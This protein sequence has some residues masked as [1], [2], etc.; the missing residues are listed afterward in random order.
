[1]SRYWTL[2]IFIFAFEFAALMSFFA[3][4]EDKVISRMRFLN[5]S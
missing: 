5:K 1:M 3:P 4:H 2:L